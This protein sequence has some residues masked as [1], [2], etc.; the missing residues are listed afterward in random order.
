MSPSKSLYSMLLQ[1]LLL[2]LSTTSCILLEL[3]IK[4][5]ILSNMIL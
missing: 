2:L 1:P 5:I 3:K 4:L